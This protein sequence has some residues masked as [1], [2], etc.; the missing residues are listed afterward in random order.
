MKALADAFVA[1]YA[2][3]RQLRALTRYE[4]TL[5]VHI[6]PRIG[7]VLIDQLTREHVRTLVKEVLVRA[8]RGHEGRSRVR[9]GTEAARSAMSILRRMIGWAIE[10]GKTPR[11]DNPVSGMGKNLPRKHQ[12][13]RVL[14]LEEARIAWVAADA[15]GYPFGPVYRLLL[16]TGCRPGEWSKCR[17]TFIDLKQALLV[18]PASDFKSQHV[19]V[20]RLVKEAVR[21]LAGVLVQEAL[22]GPYVFSGTNGQ[23]PLAGWPKAHRRLLREICALSGERVTVKWTPHDLRRT[24]ATQSPRTWAS[25]G[26][27]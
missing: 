17:R 26:S 5:R 21:I 14:S 24:V 3:M 8:P 16:L 12:R 1:D 15:L 11:T 27:S 23:R 2:R 19:H 9:G 6:I 4:S 10:E 20:V 18:V 7:D 22:T 13:E 25:A